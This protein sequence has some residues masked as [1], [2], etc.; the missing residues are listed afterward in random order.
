VRRAG[1]Q[2]ACASGL[3]WRSRPRAARDER[4]ESSRDQGSKRAD[5][6]EPGGAW[7][8]P[9]ATTAPRWRAERGS[10]TGPPRAL[11]RSQRHARARDP[12]G[13]RLELCAWARR[14]RRGRRSRSLGEK[15]QETG[16]RGAPRGASGPRST[17]AARRR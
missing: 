6:D 5:R 1:V 10:R 9:R 15:K 2:N 3:D 14:P 11:P 12:G 17:T 8:G 7:S 16:N 13:E 4:L